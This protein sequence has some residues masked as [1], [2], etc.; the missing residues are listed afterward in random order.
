M[1]SSKPFSALL[2]KIG[3]NRSNKFNELNDPKQISTL[4]NSGNGITS[5]HD[6]LSIL[7]RATELK[8]DEFTSTTLDSIISTLQANTDPELKSNL[9]ANNIS[10]LLDVLLS[11]RMASSRI[12]ERCLRIICSLLAED[13]NRSKF[14]SSG[15]CYRLVKTCQLH[16]SDSLLLLWGLRVIRLLTADE[17]LVSKFAVSGACDL[18]ASVLHHH[19]DK[20]VEIVEWCCRVIYN[21]CYEDVNCCL[22]L[23]ECGVCE[24]IVAQLR[25]TRRSKSFAN[26]NILNRLVEDEDIQ[27][28]EGTQFNEIVETVEL[29]EGWDSTSRKYQYLILAMGSM[30]RR[31]EGNKE[32]FGWLGACEAVIHVTNQFTLNDV[33]LSESIC[34]T[35]GNLTYPCT[36]NQKRLCDL[37]AS[38][39][40][41]DIL[42]KHMDSEKC[43]IECL[44]AIRNIAHNFDLA[45]AALKAAGSVIVAMTSIIH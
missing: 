5:Y 42:N 10:N 23:A 29:S 38:T 25:P 4:L 32:R 14:S 21:L 2:S 26:D 7:K 40:V 24:M 19:R 41:I 33:A 44:R 45:L 39:V 22:K 6:L 11:Q 37:Q 20:D 8:D 30:S 1:S 35:L 28:T 34:W 15:F 16:S 18:V 27:A 13:G 31:H 9:V 12:C 36:A 43:A 17:S 3:F